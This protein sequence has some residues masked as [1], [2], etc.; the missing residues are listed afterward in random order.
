MACFPPTHFVEPGPKIPV[1]YKNKEKDLVCKQLIC[2]SIC[3]LNDIETENGTI[4]APTSGAG[5]AKGFYVILDGDFDHA[6]D[7]TPTDVKPYQVG[8]PMDAASLTQ[9]HNDGNELNLTTGI[10]TCP[11]TGLYDISYYFRVINTN[12][13]AGLIYGILVVMTGSYGEDSRIM[14]VSVEM[15]EV[16]TVANSQLNGISSS[17]ALQAIR[18]EAGGTVKLRF[19]VSGGD[20]AHLNQA[21]G[22]FSI[23][24]RLR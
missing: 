15:D 5:I 9:C 19:A 18:M 22:Y 23:M 10:W 17:G 7:S 1:N 14:P 13:T 11:A 4:S 20:E 2:E 3:A 16:S 12:G 6:G 8:D 24:P 21:D